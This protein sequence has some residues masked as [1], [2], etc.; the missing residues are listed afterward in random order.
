MLISILNIIATICVIYFLSCYLIYTKNCKN[1]KKWVRQFIGSYI[2][3][4]KEIPNK[5]IRYSL[6]L[7]YICFWF[8]FIILLN[9]DYSTWL[10]FIST[11]MTYFCGMFICKDDKT[12]LSK[13]HNGILQ[14]SIWT[15]IVF[16]LVRSLKYWFI[17]IPALCIPLIPYFIVKHKKQPLGI[18]NELITFDVLYLW[19]II[20]TVLSQYIA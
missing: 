6:L 2:F 10:I 14:A 1:N 4:N 7:C 12:I 8:I 9:S 16:V 13:I 19:L 5:L 11:T 15:S 18:S 20:F 3:W 17:T